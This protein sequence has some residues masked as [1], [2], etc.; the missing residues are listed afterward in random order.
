MS[1]QHTFPVT[2]IVQSACPVS[3]LPYASSSVVLVLPNLGTL[4]NFSV[5]LRMCPFLCP[6][7]KDL[8]LAELGMRSWEWSWEGWREQAKWEGETRWAVKTDGGKKPTQNW[9]LG[10]IC[11][12]WPQGLHWFFKQI[13]M[14]GTQGATWA[15]C[16]CHLD[17]QMKLQNIVPFDVPFFIATSGQLAA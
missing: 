9:R 6:G 16:H 2:S 12:A 14:M 8:L 17:V 15:I 10:Y 11:N 4:R 3:S 7:E 5:N 1:C 13:V